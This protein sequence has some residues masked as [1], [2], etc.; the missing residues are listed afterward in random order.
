MKYANIKLL[1]DENRF[2]RFLLLVIW[3][4]GVVLGA[5]LCKPFYS[6][7][8]G[9]ALLQST[10]IVGLLAVLFFPLLC[11]S[12]SFYLH[13]PSF[14]L[15]LAFGKSVCF[16]FSAMLI[17]RVF[18]SA[19]WLV[20]ILFLFSDFFTNLFLMILWAVYFSGNRENL[21]LDFLVCF[22]ALLAIGLV[23]YFVISPF[24]QGL[25]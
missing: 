9:S 17:L 21:E 22:I 14:L 3:I 1:S 19:S 12:F 8:M 5:A 25:F 13:W 15:G 24:L 23:D 2:F 11:T 16:G 20:R 6:P 18:Y 10:S 7:L 4:V